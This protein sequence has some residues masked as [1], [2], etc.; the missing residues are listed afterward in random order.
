M[1]LVV[2]VRNI[3]GGGIVGWL[4]GA[5][6]AVGDPDL[7]LSR[8]T[9]NQRYVYEQQRAAPVVAA[10]AMPSTAACR[11]PTSRRYAMDGLAVA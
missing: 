9:T 3:G 2:I 6:L 8:T 10:G 5:L 4:I 1:I 7:F 11:S